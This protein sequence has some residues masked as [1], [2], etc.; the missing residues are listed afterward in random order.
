MLQD[1][2]DAAIHLATGQAKGTAYFVHVAMLCYAGGFL[3]RNQVTLR[4][5]V[6]AGS[7]LYIVY[8]IFH[9]AT[10]LWDAV[11]A[12]AVIGLANLYGL[13]RL[14][15]DRLPLFMGASREV[16]EAFERIGPGKMR[17]GDVRRLMRHRRIEIAS[18]RLEVTRAG[19]HPPH[20]VLL[21]KGRAELRKNGVYH[22]VDPCFLGEIAFITEGRASADVHLSQGS[23]YI[24][25]PAANLRVRMQ[26][27]AALDTGLRALTSYDMARKLALSAPPLSERRDGETPVMDLAAFRAA[28]Q[29]AATG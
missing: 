14:A 21:L 13:V 8:Y 27:D 29:I 11:F 12:S 6:L 2:T 23:R 22:L 19:Y 7:A 1:F 28:D 5:L 20:L 4:L 26:S 9:P 25:W 15:L 10:P 3:F 17:P 18:E 16:L 24:A